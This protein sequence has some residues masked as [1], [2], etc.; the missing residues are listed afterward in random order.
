LATAVR[1]KCC[2]VARINLAA[3][4]MQ[5]LRSR[6]LQ[7]IG[8]ALLCLACVAASPRGAA[9]QDA[10]S[11]ISSLGARGLQ[12]LSPSVPEAQRVS[13]FR[14][15]LENN[16]DLAGISRFVLGPYE[17]T[18]TPPAQQQFVPLFRDYLAHV[19]VA[20]LSR[21]ADSPFRVTGT[22]PWGGETVVI[23]QVST[24]NGSPVEIDWHVTNR[25][26]RFL[27]TDVAVNGVSMKTTQRSEFASIIQRNGGEANA[28]V[29]A[30]RQQLAEAR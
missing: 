3:E 2:P 4:I 6:V 20:R 11:F 13:G 8:A 27:V 28:L 23:S 1:A 10:A 15:L 24:G 14:Q 18:M 26:G 22:R 30:L 25:N 5:L 9:A 17:R 29:A 7:A 19:Y 12:A 21:Y 16:F